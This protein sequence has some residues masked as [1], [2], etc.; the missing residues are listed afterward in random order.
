MLFFPLIV[1][2]KRYHGLQFIHRVL[3]ISDLNFYY[4]TTIYTIGD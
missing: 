2:Y 1:I 3:Y 4:L